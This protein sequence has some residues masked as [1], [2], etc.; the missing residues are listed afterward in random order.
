M[1][2]ETSQIPVTGPGTC[3][4]LV[5]I[6]PG[7]AT[8]PDESKASD[9]HARSSQIWYENALKTS[10]Q[11]LGRVGFSRTF[12][13][14]TFFLWS[15][16]LRYLCPCKKRNRQSLNTQHP[17][18]V[19]IETHIRRFNI[20][21]P[22]HFSIDFWELVL[23]NCQCKEQQFFMDIQF[24]LIG[25]WMKKKKMACALPTRFLTSYSSATRHEWLNLFSTR[26]ECFTSDIGLTRTRLV[27]LVFLTSLL[28]KTVTTQNIKNLWNFSFGYSSAP[29]FVRLTEKVW[30]VGIKERQEFLDG[31]VLAK[32]SECARHTP[33]LARIHVVHVSCGETIAG[34]DC[35]L[36][37]RGKRERE[38]EREREIEKDKG[39]GCKGG[40]VIWC[41][42][43][44]RVACLCLCL[45]VYA[46]V[47]DKENEGQTK[48]QKK[49]VSSTQIYMPLKNYE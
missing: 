15:C 27:S 43:V 13:L 4:V 24:F 19:Q 17:S 31:L 44:V 30:R 3:L 16:R 8:R 34:D 18:L 48:Q 2:N 26:H 21:P 29:F 1:R 40:W 22:P 39:E 35:T 47:Y 37:E 14:L 25:F 33:S 41:V 7:R 45:Y 10:S 46:F 11:A 6:W 23:V 20:F 28:V 38:R 49:G 36:R 42:C 32:I 12:Y 5:S 9:S